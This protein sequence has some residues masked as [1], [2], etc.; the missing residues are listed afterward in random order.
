MLCEK[1]T[2]GGHK[3]YD[4][5]VKVIDMTIK[6]FFKFKRATNHI[7]NADFNF[8]WLRVAEND[9]LNPSEGELTLKAKV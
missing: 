1:T 7:G 4:E 9:G 8:N 2:C 5:G 3:C 6:S